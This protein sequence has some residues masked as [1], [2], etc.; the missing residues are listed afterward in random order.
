[1]YIPPPTLCRRSQ[2]DPVPAGLFHPPA[3][4][5]RASKTPPQRRGQVQNPK[6][7]TPSVSFLGT[8]LSVLVIFMSLLVE[9]ICKGAVYS[10]C[11]VILVHICVMFRHPLVVIFS[12][13]I[14]LLCQCQYLYVSF[15]GTQVTVFYGIFSSR[16]SP[17]PRRRCVLNPLTLSYNT[18]SPPSMC[19]P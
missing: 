19:I 7:K 18:Y 5:H 13:I 17:P 3:G 8:F 2:P 12:A 14:V 16:P 10:V 4:P 9:H 11:A 1:V 6:L 15:S